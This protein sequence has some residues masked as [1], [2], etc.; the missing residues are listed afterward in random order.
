MK[1]TGGK[2]PIPT[3]DT[4]ATDAQA[5][6]AAPRADRVRDVL[7]HFR[8]AFRSV[9][10]HADWV[11]TQC[12]L[13]GAQLWALW[14]LLMKPG[15]KVSELSK[16]MAIH[17]STTS[18]LLD[19]LERKGLVQRTRGGP[20]QRVVRLALTAQGLDIINRAP[21]PAQGVL[22]DALERLPDD[23]LNQL[24]VAMMALIKE[25]NIRDEQAALRPLSEN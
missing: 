20:D 8:I 18:N 14:E 9:Q 13:S 12:G 5:P 10:K 16:A 6:K 15:M 24:H 1:S 17:Q 19:K 7:Q 22:T 4:P 25:L 3:P 23:T 11:E 2:S 21:R